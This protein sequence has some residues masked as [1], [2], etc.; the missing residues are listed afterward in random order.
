MT[1]KIINK[2]KKL[3]VVAATVQ[4]VGSTTELE[5]S[6]LSSK[7]KDVNNDMSWW[8]EY[9]SAEEPIPSALAT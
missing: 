8:S 5:M 2:T 6:H 4:Q 1:A 3:I 7:S 9:L